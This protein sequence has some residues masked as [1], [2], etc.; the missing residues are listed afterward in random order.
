MITVVTLSHWKLNNH[1][2]M[3]SIHHKIKETAHIL[4]T[5][6]TTLD[7]IKMLLQSPNNDTYS[8]PLICN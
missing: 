3:T 6:S 5:S 2:F 1:E 8:L 7:R 4:S